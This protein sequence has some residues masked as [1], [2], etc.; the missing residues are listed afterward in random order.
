MEK[1]GQVLPKFSVARLM[2]TFECLLQVSSRLL[3]DALIAVIY[4]LIPSF[5][6]L[7]YDWDPS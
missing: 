2:G 6:T 4:F 5:K 3:C 1:R 7:V